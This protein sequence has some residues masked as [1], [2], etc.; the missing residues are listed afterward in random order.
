MPTV[1]IDLVE[2]ES[3]EYRKKV[4]KIV[5]HTFLD[6][7]RV[8]KHERSQV[9]AEHVLGKSYQENRLVLTDRVCIVCGDA[10]FDKNVE[11]GNF[12]QIWVRFGSG[13]PFQRTP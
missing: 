5:Y 1:R 11:C 9:I 4:G 13:K 10:A 6:I 3:E 12:L 7:L 8:P 2:G